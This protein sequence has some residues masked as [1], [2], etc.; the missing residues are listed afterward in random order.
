MLDA[1]DAETSVIA[2][3]SPNNPTGGVIS[4][5]DLRRLSEGAPQAILM[6]DLAYVEFANKDLTPVALELPNAVV[7]RTFSKARGLAG[8]RVGYALGPARWL[9]VLRSVGLPYPVSA[10][11]LRPQVC[12]RGGQGSAAAAPRTQGT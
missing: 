1:C 6:V 5:Q 8:L 11:A 7:F 2:V 3:V 12:S 4:S 9:N 10:P